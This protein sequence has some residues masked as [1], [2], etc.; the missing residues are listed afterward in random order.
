MPNLCE[1]RLEIRGPK[2][3]IA[4]IIAATNLSK[5]EFDFNGIVPMAPELD[6]PIGGEVTLGREVLFGNWTAMMA[7]PDFRDLLLEVTCGILPT[8]REELIHLIEK[9]DLLYEKSNRIAALVNL[10]AAKQARANL[11]KYCASDWYDWSTSNWGT[12][13]NGGEVK[14][15][16]MT[17]VSFIITFVTSRTAPIPVIAALCK[18]YPDVTV[19][20]AY[21]DPDMRYAGKLTGIEGYLLVERPVDFSSFV[22]EEFGMSL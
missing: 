8:T 14:I 16:L 9:K 18:Q 22:E 3:T 6:I 10:D 21:V 12:S 11:E 17:A 7:Q 19:E 4:A 1:N 5:G 15:E 20:M 13:W 2:E